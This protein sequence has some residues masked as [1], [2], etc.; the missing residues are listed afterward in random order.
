MSKPTTAPP[1][2][3]ARIKAAR[4][5]AGYSIR[6]AAAAHGKSASFIQH[7]ERSDCRFSTVVDLVEALELN[8]VVI[9]PELILPVVARI[10]DILNLDS[11]S[12]A[13]LAEGLGL[14]PS[15]VAPEL[16]QPSAPT[17]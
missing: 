17:E 2:V 11:D 3:G 15:A 7:A 4:I 5:K 10:A 9:A 8:P 6:S 13:R 1:L 12:I 16:C 14:D